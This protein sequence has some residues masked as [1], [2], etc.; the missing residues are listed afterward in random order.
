[1]F[2]LARIIR[3]NDACREAKQ[4]GRP[5]SA[6]SWPLKK[7][8]ADGLSLAIVHLGDYARLLGHGEWVDE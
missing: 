4:N 6:P 7:E 3:V 2:A 8:Y 5:M 1:M